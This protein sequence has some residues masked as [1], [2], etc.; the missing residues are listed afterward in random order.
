MKEGITMVY[1]SKKIEVWNKML[2]IIPIT[3]ERNAKDK[4]NTQRDIPGILNPSDVT[5]RSQL[6]QAGHQDCWI[7]SL[8]FLYEDMLAC[9]TDIPWMV[10]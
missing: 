5:T 4:S 3:E 9:P 8:P 10:R 7:N 6:D 2:E 1:F